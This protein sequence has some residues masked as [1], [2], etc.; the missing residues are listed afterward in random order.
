MKTLR[1]GLAG[2]KRCMVGKTSCHL[3][4]INQDIG[5]SQIRC[6]SGEWRINLNKMNEIAIE[7]WNWRWTAVWKVICL[8]GG[9]VGTAKSPSSRALRVWAKGWKR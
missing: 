7:L 5:L 3:V 4:E 9:S 6:Q 8:I 2:R 1:F